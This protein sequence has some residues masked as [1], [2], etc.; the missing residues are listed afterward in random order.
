M[1]VEAT[2][3]FETLDR[4]ILAV[5]LRSELNEVP[6]T[7][8]ERIGSGIVERIENRPLPLVIVDLTELTQM[9]SA[10]VAM[11]VRI[12][13][14]VSERG[15]QMV[16][17]NRNEVV[18]EVLEI[19][20]LASKWTIVPT[21]DEARAVIGPGGGTP[22]RFVGGE[23][24]TGVVL[25]GLSALFL[26]LA[27]FGIADAV[28]DGLVSDSLG[29]PATFW[30]GVGCAIVAT[31]LGVAAVLRTF[32]TLKLVAVVLSTLAVVTGLGSV[33]FVS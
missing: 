13:K 6:W 21:R 32:G 23:T 10:I 33:L 5:T 4:D 26:L 1:P 18:G 7:D 30:L 28:A 8:I 31:L 12:W 11:V 15:G 9:G 17:V 20:G 3:R 16:V 19:S 14:T 27:V 22:S 29:G 2:C 24:R 25:T